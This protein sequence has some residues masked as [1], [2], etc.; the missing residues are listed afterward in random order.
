M[1]LALKNQVDKLWQYSSIVFKN[2][3]SLGIDKKENWKKMLQEKKKIRRKNWISSCIQ[4]VYFLTTILSLKC[5]HKVIYPIDRN[6]NIIFHQ[7]I[8][9]TAI[10]WSNLGVGI[11][12]RPK[13]IR[14]KTV[15]KLHSNDLAI[16]MPGGSFIKLKPVS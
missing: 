16:S 4:T 7:G 15:L 14:S 9:P 13:K 2:F 5:Q 10:L 3:W 11:I 12:W 6:T 1:T 8:L